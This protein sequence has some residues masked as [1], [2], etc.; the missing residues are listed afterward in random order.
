V[1]GIGGFLVGEFTHKVGEVMASK[2][3]KHDFTNELCF[4]S[5]LN[6]IIWKKNVAQMGL[7]TAKLSN[8]DP[9]RNVCCRNRSK[10]QT[11]AFHDS[12]NGKS[13]GTI[14]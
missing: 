7:D 13:I 6:S 2:W 11:G 12:T 9:N 1:F 14:R 3:E 5:L 4:F 8:L 10:K